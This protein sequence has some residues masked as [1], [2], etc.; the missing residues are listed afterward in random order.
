MYDSIKPLLRLFLFWMLFFFIQRIVFLTINFTSFNGTSTE[1]F[2]TNI[3]AIPVDIAASYYLISI[4]IV[5]VIIGLF[6]TNHKVINRVIEIESKLMIVLCAFIGSG[7]AGLY[8]V[9]GTKI[10]GKALSYFA[11]PQEIFPT[12]FAKENIGLFLIVLAQ[13]VFAFWLF[14][15]VYIETT[16]IELHFAYKPT[17]SV[18]V[19]ALFVIGIRGGIQ[20][21]PLN[22]NWIYHSPHALLN[23]AALNGFWNVA[24]ILFRPLESNRNPYSYFK[25]QQA[26]MM[27]KQMHQ[28]AKDSTISIL[29][30]SRPNIVIVFLES[31]AAD[32]IE[33]VG[34][35][36]GVAPQFNELARE[37]LLFTNF[38]S[39]GFRTEQGFLATLSAY[40]AQPVSSIIHSFDKFDKL[41]HLVKTFN[42]LDYHTSFYSGGRLQFDNIEAYMQAAGVK[43]MVGEDDFE[44][45]RRTFWAAYDEETLAMHLRELNNTP[46]PFF[47]AVTTMTTHEWYDADIPACF[48]GDPDPIS[49]KYRCT[50]HYADSCVYAYIK[51]AQQ[52]PWYQNTLLILVAD[53][54]CKFPKHRANFETERHHI[55]LLMIGGALKSEF[56]GQVNNRIASHI[57]IPATILSQLSVKSTD[58]PRSKNIFNPYSQAFAYYTFDNGFGMITKDKAV[59]YDH[60]QQKDIFNTTSDEQSTE[61]INFGKA[62]LQT[63]Y[64][65]TLDFTQPLK[66][67]HHRAYR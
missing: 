19:I 30:K 11:Y 55:P 1:L 67:G 22:R 27:L 25:P 24:D 62:Y 36:K 17:L 48:S 6:M 47:S 32:V 10:N 18:I 29:N 54:A 28:T 66:V 57:D 45:K 53:H 20:R 3:K 5:A 2:L 14:N 65:E 16:S 60:N 8:K 31:W 42:N 35:E 39:T 40:P 46:Q 52:Q 34:G 26:D 51:A 63:H 9:W 21:I 56:T 33:C 50:M 58:Y 41:P 12:L 49:D 59:I 43:K 38:Y 64:Q 15:K 7:D 13:I 61:L 23:Y 37:G 4:P 44:I